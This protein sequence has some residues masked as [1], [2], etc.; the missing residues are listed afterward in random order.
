MIKT[1]L[2]GSWT[3]AYFPDKEAPIDTD[4]FNAHTDWTE[5]TV[6]GCW[7]IQTDIPRRSQGAVVFKKI[8]SASVEI[9]TTTYLN[10]DAVNYYCMVW[11]ND[12]LIGEN[13]GG[14]NSFDF[15]ITSLLKPEGNTLYVYVLKQGEKFPAWETTVG[16][17]PDI[18]YNYGGIYRDVFL[19]QYGKT[20]IKRLILDGDPKAEKIYVKCSCFNFSNITE[21]ALRIEA[22]SPC[23][24]RIVSEQKIELTTGENQWIKGELSVP[25]PI[26]WDLDSPKLYEI[27]VSIVI[28]GAVAD[29]AVK[30]V[31]MRS[32]ELKGA[33]VLL[34]GIPVYIRGVLHW[35]FYP[36][37]IAPTPTREE[38]KR[39]IEKVKAHGF[40]MVKHCL[41]IP[42]DDYFEL[43]D[44][45]GLLLWQE[46]PMWLPDMKDAL[47]SR[48]NR[49]YP[50]MMEKV[51]GHP[52][53]IIYTIGCELNDT[54]PESFLKGLY[55]VIKESAMGALITDN[56]GSGECYGSAS[57]AFA[58]FYDYHF[59][60]ELHNFET[61]MEVFTPHCRKEKPWMYG[62]F[63]DYDTIC[64]RDAIIK[65]QGKTPWWLSRDLDVN[66]IYKDC[67]H[68][69]SN[70]KVI[71]LMEQDIILESQ[72]YVKNN[73]ER[74]SS[75]SMRQGLLHRKFCLEETRKFPEVCGYN[76]T[77]ITDS[78]LSSSGVFD[79]KMDDKFD[80]GL[81]RGFNG[82]SVLALSWDLKR[83]WK[84]GGDRTAYSDRYNYFSKESIKLHMVLSHY[85]S[86]ELIYPLVRL[87]LK[88][89]D[90]IIHMSEHKVNTAIPRSTVSELFAAVIPLPE[91]ISPKKL[92]LY[93]ELDGT[94]IKNQ[95]DFY[96]Y[97][98]PSLEP[99]KTVGL[100]DPTGAYSELKEYFDEINCFSSLVKLSDYKIIFA[101]ILDE[102]IM[103]YTESGGK[104]CYIQNEA[105]RLPLLRA[106]FW[107]ESV[108]MV[109]NHPI[110]SDIIFDG[111][112]ELNAFGVASDAAF[113]PSGLTD[114]SDVKPILVRVDG[115][116]Y[117]AS[118]YMFEGE[119]GKGK[120]IGT[121]LRLCGGQG[122]QPSGIKNNKFA[123][124]LIER[125]IAFFD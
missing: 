103:S 5:I 3:Y 46:F 33:D 90:D 34:N 63:C 55:D 89:G 17:L 114:F 32:I 102:K 109:E 115:R 57:T 60:A 98:E 43:A 122:K 6:P 124:V 121:T 69:S 45:M 93:A 70:G 59:Y 112:L 21:A 67:H 82:E 54:V 75:V 56:S 16:F 41:Y 92:T 119:Y 100:Y 52:S 73:I 77:A 110:T 42:A 61:L 51:A 2:A 86:T 11:L 80:A 83:T 29:S 79:Y 18:V 120:L 50:L 38:I 88:S 25:E 97:P 19:A 78:T 65:K 37:I 20:G 12:K 125:I 36:D 31:G 111:G 68:Y 53:V 81:F 108:R 62:E 74:I 94:D 95:W 9:N 40:N 72:P 71:P 118:Y 47:I 49:E 64:N 39:E 48:Y 116:R 1:S 44:E 35:G 26:L 104:V 76:I 113:E 14:W 101:T 99:S 13:E 107:R 106:A 117:T 58:E 87:R 10:F 15:D 96:A 7:D 23:G 105:G 84:N 22:V 24:K 30:K 91:V 66:P 85:G 4:I 27:T 28:S 8:F 123:K